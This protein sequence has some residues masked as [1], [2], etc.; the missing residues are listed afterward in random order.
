MSNI[1]WQGKQNKALQADEKVVFCIYTHIFHFFNRNIIYIYGKSTCH[2]R[3]VGKKQ[4][5]TKV[6]FFNDP[7]LTDQLQDYVKIKS[8]CMLEI[9]FNSPM[10]LTG[11]KMEK[12]IKHF[13]EKTLPINLMYYC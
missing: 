1:Y 2:G 7:F 10:D 9:H 3:P 4:T 13:K 5:N 8:T 11:F 6:S 12:N